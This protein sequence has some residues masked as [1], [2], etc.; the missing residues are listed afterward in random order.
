VELSGTIRYMAP[1]VQKQIH[2]E[3]E[4]ALQVSRALGGDFQS[5][6]EI[7][8]PPMYNDARMVDQ[9]RE[10]IT[11]LLGAQHIK[12]PQPSMGAEDFGFFSNLVPG[13]MF[14]LGCRIEGDERKHHSPRF[15][16]DELL[17][18]GRLSWQ[19]AP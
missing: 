12:P 16:L 17:T 7:G 10:V 2:A 15:D 19:K 4:R 8:Y 14:Y 5:R 18:M 9:V 3:I 11:D 13:V 6:I 1:E